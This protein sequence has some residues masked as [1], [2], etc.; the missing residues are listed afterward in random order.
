MKILKQGLAL[1]DEDINLI[2]PKIL[3][4]MM[5]NRLVVEFEEAPDLDNLDFKG[6]KGFYYIKSLGS[7]LYQFWFENRQDFDAFYNNLIA[8][9]MT[10]SNSDK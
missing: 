2:D 5:K 1:S 3:T 8:Y 7:K 4:I 10:L 9:K 6:C